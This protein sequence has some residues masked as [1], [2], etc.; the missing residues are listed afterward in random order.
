MATAAHERHGDRSF[1]GS[2]H[3]RSVG[4]RQDAIP[5]VGLLIYG[6]IMGKA[7]KEVEFSFDPAKDFVWGC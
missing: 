7:S 1:A 3:C 4:R 5:T 6:H 2:R